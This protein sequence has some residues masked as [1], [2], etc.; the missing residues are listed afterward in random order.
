MMEEHVLKE[1]KVEEEITKILN[2][3]KK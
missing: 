2:L 1:K 3:Y